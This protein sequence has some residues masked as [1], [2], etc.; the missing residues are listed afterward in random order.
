M[1]YLCI[2]NR[3][4]PTLDPEVFQASE[5]EAE[6]FG[7]DEDRAWPLEGVVG[8]DVDIFGTSRSALNLPISHH[9]CA[10]ICPDM[11]FVLSRLLHICHS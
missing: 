7:S 3:R 1:F 10:Y 11:K 6:A 9:A 5:T 4:S 8:E 2:E